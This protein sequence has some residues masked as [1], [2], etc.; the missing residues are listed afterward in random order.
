MFGGLEIKGESSEKN[1]VEKDRHTSVDHP[2]HT[3]NSASTATHD[4]VVATA[5]VPSSTVGQSGF[6]FLS[7][8]SFSTS[9]VNPNVDSEADTKVDPVVISTTSSAFGFLAQSSSSVP[10]TS[11]N[12]A[13][14]SIQSQQ[15]KEQ[16]Q[17]EEDLNA[18]YTPENEKDPKV[19]TE[20]SLLSC[21]LR[22]PEPMTS[23]GFSFLST[24]AP[25]TSSSLEGQDLNPKPK[26]SVNHVDDEK[27]HVA[28]ASS[29]GNSMFSMLQVK[30][31]DTSSSTATTTKSQRTTI[32]Q[33]LSSHNDLLSLSNPSLP[34]SSATSS[35]SS[36]AAEPPTGSGIVFGGAV[37]KPKTMVKKRG[38]TKKIGAGSVSLNTGGSAL[39]SISKYNVNV[40]GTT[41]V[42]EE[43]SAHVKEGSEGGDF[44]ALTNEA[45][46]AV[47]RAEEF[48]S[49]KKSSS[50]PTSYSTGR[51]SD[52]NSKTVEEDYG[53]DSYKSP[54]EEMSNGADGGI[55]DYERA[56]M[57]AQE[58][59][60]KEAGG[61]SF[62]LSSASISASTSSMR[63]I[64]FGG[65]ISGFFKRNLAGGTS[66]SVVGEKKHDDNASSF[67]QSMNVS[68]RGMK[69]LHDHSIG[70]NPRGKDYHVGRQE[71]A[72]DYIGK[73]EEEDETQAEAMR[74]NMDKIE[75]EER[76]LEVETQQR[77]QQEEMDRKLAEESRLL[78][79]RRKEEERARAEEDRKRREA[80]EAAN[81]TPERMLQRLI[82][83]FS[84]KS[85]SATLAVANLRQERATMLDKRT[86][87]EKQSRMALQQIAQAEKQQM[88]AAEQED[89]ELA[90]R[91]AAVIEQHQREKEELTQVLE[92]FEGIIEDL[93]YRRLDVVKRVWLCFIGVQKELQDFLEQQENS[94]ITDD[95]EIWRKFEDD[96]KKLAAENERL[97]SYL[98]NIE[99]DEGFAKEE[100][101]EL[102]ATIHE[103]TSGIEELRD[104]ATEKLNIINAEIDELRRQLE[105]K[106]MEAAQVKL[107]LHEH[108]DSIE[109][110][111]NKFSRQLHRLEKKESA[112][113]ESRKE[114]ETEELIYKK[115]RENLEAEVTAHSEAIVAHDKILAQVKDE[116]QV[117]EELAKIIAQ[118]VMVDRGSDK[119]CVDKDLIKIQSEV[120]E[121]EAAAEEANEVLTAATAV[122]NGLKEEIASIDKRLPMLESEKKIAAAN[123]D[124]KAAARAS[125]EI[126]ELTSRKSKCDED[127][128][129]TAL[130][131]QESAKKFVDDCLQKLEEKKA[132]AHE[133]EK[134]IGVKRM[135]ELVKKIIN[136]ENLREEVC[137]TDEEP[138][139]NVKA[140]GGFV[141]DSEISALMMEGEELDKRF[142]GWNDI[143]LEYASKESEDEKLVRDNDDDAPQEVECNDKDT[144]P[145]TT[146]E[147]NEQSN[148]GEDDHMENAETF[149]EGTEHNINKAEII[150]KFKDMHEQL[151]G[152]ELKLENAIET[153]E[154]EIA[155][156][157][158]D[159]IAMIKDM[160]ESLDLSEEDKIQVVSSDTTNANDT[161][162]KK[163]GSSLP[164]EET[165]TTSNDLADELNEELGH[166]NDDDD[167]EHL[168]KS[169]VGTSEH[170]GTNPD[171]DDQDKSATDGTDAIDGDSTSVPNDDTNVQE[172]QAELSDVEL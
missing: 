8:S 161:A 151:L 34:M 122:I 138:L 23:S 101:Q 142:G 150:A 143:M 15:D 99:R 57:A 74:C 127:L 135:I 116:I 39:T 6:S 26:V 55:D 144:M 56:K 87:A 121:L 168:D 155:A 68:R 97:M 137:G 28:P 48:I 160:M 24:A 115:A 83:E 22:P 134:E 16:G 162:E 12:Q 166:E 102:E 50:V 105:A 133:K 103:Q 77:L 94:D 43:E 147:D 65:G 92:K 59:M 156:E 172:R 132:V 146:K 38:R 91:L 108:E 10:M 85:Q 5:S 163:E 136:L 107:E 141:L 170:S 119:D 67:G 61:S 36:L 19:K 80:Q 125:K 41:G 120:L 27:Q 145:N 79:E 152:L 169:S 139:E 31:Q 114:W 164:L 73:E 49:S 32:S 113:R 4:P 51:Y 63:K 40:D 93:D 52:V 29:V 98:K 167:D 3:D 78:E 159:Q 95:T 11:T 130:E 88:E 157:L 64:G 148:V 171:M 82:Q 25:A 126:K 7:S 54:G 13:P 44:R 112:V 30:T 53:E 60:K 104:V 140:V 33:P 70:Y 9:S 131:R 37:T 89:F 86:S 45:N 69:E 46:E 84:N 2:P 58:A 149:N 75:Q 106:E 110:I 90:D 47:S 96:T 81:R 117:A 42:D 123:R 66:G 17:K 71:N 158:D 154:Y 20:D 111:R 62:S 129:G 165:F 124:F 118:E 100:R 1:K 35:S 128:Q 153:E 14:V 21:V 109:Q 76:R 18:T 72:N